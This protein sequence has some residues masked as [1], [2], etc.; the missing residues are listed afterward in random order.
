VTKFYVVW[1]GRKTGIFKSWSECE[2]QVKGFDGARFKSFA[3]RELAEHALRAGPDVLVVPPEIA[4]SYAVDA[5]CSGSPGPLEY[6][7]VDLKTGGEIFRQGPFAD[8]TN[9]IGEFLAIVHAL[10]LFK[11]KG[12]ALPIYSD[13]ETALSWIKAK[14]CKT[15]LRRTARNAELFALIERAELWL[16]END[17]RNP[18]KKWAT[19]K[20]GENPA[21]FGRK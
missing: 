6:R 15:K 19:E 10:S 3:T 12:I 5:A 13:S 17:Y 18:L 4:E 16:A 1:A 14:R 8:G 20:W 21:D 7:C 9:N 2:T 11:Q